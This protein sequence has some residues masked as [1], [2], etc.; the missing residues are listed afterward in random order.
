MPSLT[1]LAE[2]VLA[3]TKRLDAYLESKGLPYTDFQEDTLSNLP[4]DLETTRNA[5]VD[6]AQTLK[7][8]ALGP[9]GV[10][11]EIL[12]SVLPTETS[13]T[14]RFNLPTHH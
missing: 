13:P 12:F 6:S 11:T 10:Y 8:L 3:N 5:L 7:R 14:S 4:L 1:A 9:G 2:E